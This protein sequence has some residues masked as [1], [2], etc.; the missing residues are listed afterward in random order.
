[1][2]KNIEVNQIKELI[3][4]YRILNQKHYNKIDLK[5]NDVD[6]TK[7]NTVSSLR[8]AVLYKKIAKEIK[9]GLSTFGY[10]DIE[11]TDILVKYLYDIKDSKRKEALWFCYGEHIL[12]NLKR[13]VKKPTKTIQCVDCGEWLDIDKKNRRTCRCEEC[14]KKEKRRLLSERVRKCRENKKVG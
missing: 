6:T 8:Q 4:M 1:M 2:D 11:I 14:Q 5:S 9:E 13:N 7:C 3:D 10:S 12:D